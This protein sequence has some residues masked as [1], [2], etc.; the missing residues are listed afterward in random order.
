MKWVWIE[1]IEPSA[2]S[3]ATA[4]FLIRRMAVS[5]AISDFWKKL[6]RERRCPDY[7]Q[8]SLQLSFLTSCHGPRVVADLTCS[9]FVIDIFFK[10]VACN[11]RFTFLQ[12]RVFGNACHGGKCVSTSLC[13]RSFRNV[14]F[15]PGCVVCNIQRSRRHQPSRNVAERSAADFKGIGVVGKAWLLAPSFPRGRFNRIES[16]VSRVRFWL[17]VEKSLIDLLLKIPNAPSNVS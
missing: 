7:H 13:C 15:K 11:R 2:L 9:Y 5:T 17:V 4:K 16:P 3:Q 6:R 8:G 14:T 12:G 1:D 10:C